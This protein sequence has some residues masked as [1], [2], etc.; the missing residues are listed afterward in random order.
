VNNV[1]NPEIKLPFGDDY[2]TFLIYDYFG[3]GLVLVS[4]SYIISSPPRLNTPP[5]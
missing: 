1:V 2:L 3:D 4:P 5:E